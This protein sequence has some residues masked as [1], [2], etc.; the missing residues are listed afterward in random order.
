M[1]DRSSYFTSLSDFDLSPKKCTLENTREKSTLGKYINIHLNKM[2]H[3]WCFMYNVCNIYIYYI[4]KTP[5]K[6]HFTH[7]K[8]KKK[9]V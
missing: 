6:Q 1:E 5:M 4:H 9:H 7:P 2:L 3:H 8:K